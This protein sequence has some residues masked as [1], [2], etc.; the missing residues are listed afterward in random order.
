MTEQTT[1]QSKTSKEGITAAVI[2]AALFGVSAPLAKMLL[3]EIPPLR[4][5][6]LLYLGS[7]IGLSIIAAA[8]YVK[9]RIKKDISVKEAPIKGRD[10]I[11]LA[12]AV[13]CGGVL[14][15]IMLTTGLVNTSGSSAAL[16]LNL[17]GILT[18]LAAFL[19]FK[20]A[21]DKRV[22]AAIGLIIA[23]GIVISYEPS[24]QGLNFSAGALLVFGACLMWALDNN[25]TRNLSDKDPF[26]IARIKGLAAGAVS[27]SIS[28]FMNEP[29]SAVA[30]SAAALVIGA[31]SYGVSLVLFVVSLRHLGAARTG[32]YFSLGPFIGATFA[33]ILLKEPITASLVISALL[34]GVGVWLLLGEKHSHEHC[35]DEMLHDHSHV[36][37]E[38]HRHDHEEGQDCTEPHSHEH[39]HLPLTHFHAHMPDLHHR[40]LH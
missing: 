37:D 13:L 28:Y 34:M 20:E 39:L 24:K 4:L 19:F 25:F 12:L 11:W 22:W 23:G 9:K 5:A 31:F 27:I 33:V 2:A 26:A 3:G 38:H 35:H 29:A 21:I 40:H 8:G 10:Y 7:G 36:H 17:E 6:G 15:P 18:A 32:A 14:G 1:T 16:L 30:P